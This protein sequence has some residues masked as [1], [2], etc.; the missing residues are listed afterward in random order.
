MKAFYCQSGWC[1]ESAIVF[2]ETVGKAKWWFINHRCDG[3]MG[4]V[5]CRRE[6]RLDHYGSA[7]AIP[8][9]E[10]VW[11]GWWGE[12]YCCGMRIDEDT[13]NDAGMD[14]DNVQG[15]Y[16]GSIYCSPECKHEALAEREAK[17]NLEARI[18]EEMMWKLKDR[19]PGAD[20]KLVKPYTYTN[21]SRGLI[22]DARLS[23][24]VDGYAV[25]YRTPHQTEVPVDEL[26]KTQCLLMIH[27]NDFE[28][29]EKVYGLQNIS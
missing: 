28:H 5:T 12:C 18:V 19:M 16:T 13:L 23:L 6:K 14:V 24:N 3:E 11:M 1:E 27:Q 26:M 10:L 7:D 15:M 29:F 8:F 9:K 25:E 21:P 4:D 22:F 2:A 17:D 20:I